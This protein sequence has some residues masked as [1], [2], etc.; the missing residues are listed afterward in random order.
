MWRGLIFRF[1]KYCFFLI[2]LNWQNMIRS[3]PV[4]REQWNISFSPHHC[5]SVPLSLSHSFTHVHTHTRAREYWMGLGRATGCTEFLLSF[6]HTCAHVHALTHVCVC[7]HTWAHM[8]ITIGW[9]ELGRAT[10][11]IE[12]I[13]LTILWAQ[14]KTKLLCHFLTI[15]PLLNVKLPFNSLDSDI[16]GQ[17]TTISGLFTA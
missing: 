7:T 13:F 3:G 16:L 15:I 8:N 2:F 5:F 14:E 6:I 10:G 12:F 11:R 9:M 4:P 1:C 17:K